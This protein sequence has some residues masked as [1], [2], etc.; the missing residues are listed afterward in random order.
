M[1]H[2]FK[3]LHASSLHPQAKLVGSASPVEII[4]ISIFLR[5]SPDAFPGDFES[6]G[7]IDEPY[8]PHTFAAKHGAHSDEMDAVVAHL[9]SCGLIVTDTHL[10]GKRI[11]ASGTLTQ[12]AAT[13]KVS[14]HHYTDVNWKGS[15]IHFRHHPEP[16]QVPI[17]I[18]PFILGIVGLN[19][20]PADI[21]SHAVRYHPDVGQGNAVQTPPNTTGLSVATLTRLYNFPTNSAAGQTIAIFEIPELSIL[22][23]SD[24]TQYFNGLGLSAPAITDVMP[25]PTTTPSG[26]DP[27][28][29]NLDVM[30]AGTAARGAN[31]AMYYTAS[32]PGTPVGEQVIVDALFR[33][34]HPSPGDPT[35][36]VLSISYGFTVDRG[37]AGQI[38]GEDPSNG[39][40]YNQIWQD[41][42][43]R[44]LT[45]LISTGDAGSYDNS[46][47][48]FAAVN[49]P[50]SSP[51]VVA[52]G[53]TVVGNVSGS[54]FE[55]YVWNE[56]S[57][58][59]PIAT[60]GGVSLTGGGTGGGWPVPSYQTNNGV[61]PTHL[62]KGFVARGTPDISAN[63]ATLSGYLIIVNGANAQVGGTSGACPLMASLVAI[64]N[65]ANGK[66]A[67]FIN[68]TL[69]LTGN[70]TTYRDITPST[71][72]WPDNGANG[73]AGYPVKV[74]WDGSN[75]LGIPDGVKFKNILAAVAVSVTLTGIS[76]SNSTVAFGVAAGTV[77]GGITVAATGG[78]FTGTLSLGATSAT[79]FQIIGSNL[80]TLVPTLASGSYS[81]NII[82]TQAG[83][84]GSPLSMTGTVT[85]S[86]PLINLT[87]IS[88]SKS[89]VIPGSPTATVVGTIIVAATGGTFTGS[90]TL[91]GTNAAQFQIIGTNLC[92]LGV[93][94]AGVYSLNVVATQTNA[95]GS[96]FTQALTITAATA[97][98]TIT[99]VTLN[100]S[101]VSTTAPSGT[102]VGAIA[103]VLSTGS[104]TGTLT[105]TGTGAPQFQ[106]IGSNLCTSGTVPPNTYPLN[107][108]ATQ[109]GA[110]GSP[111]TQA[112]TITVTNPTLNSITLSNPNPNYATPPAIGTVITTIVVN[113]T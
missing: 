38:D 82:A 59:R 95:G 7:R 80:C 112:M 30:V 18:H 2:S 35:C 9:T 11:K 65:A 56:N 52:V 10:G 50:G 39:A 110:T 43:A 22:K 100:N 85:V 87:G 15:P 24:V 33:I 76:I 98:P 16:T 109:A 47:L 1:N 21:R 42:G 26:S 88:L 66:N 86:A 51:W 20:K 106:I 83:A 107:I 97:A 34:V 62:T 67:G 108:V 37:T 92:T 72:G 17:S 29:S 5:R 84:T 54:S 103:V 73:I 113:V 79:Q 44:G 93:V 75:G 8:H 46:T 49:F 55:E 101:V 94:P 28:E 41:G 48:G 69:Y 96:P 4:E 14:F 111:F 102:I 53:G 32:T 57:P 74:G 91:T 27:T 58:S 77:I 31:I 25:P 68:P 12:M 99:G 36:S 63:A 105:L 81:V 23:R 3:I 78:A 45:T 60:G 64:S 71:L 90:L 19:N 70:R 61:N 104:F 89:T 13:F 40:I 6:I